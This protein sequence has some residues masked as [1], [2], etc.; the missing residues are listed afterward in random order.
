MRGC[1]PHRH[2]AIVFSKLLQTEAIFFIQ[3]AQKAFG[4]WAPPK[5]A[6]VLIALRRP[7]RAGKRRQERVTR[8]SAIAEGPR[9]AMV[10][11]V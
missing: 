9:D 8:S 1:S 5:P 4:D 11:F 2:R 10:L 7:L 6:G 3:N